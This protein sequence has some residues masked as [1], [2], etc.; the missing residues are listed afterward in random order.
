VARE[1]AAE[2]RG[3]SVREDLVPLAGRCSACGH[4][5]VDGICEVCNRSVGPM[6]EAEEPLEPPTSI[7]LPPRRPRITFPVNELS[8]IELPAPHP[9]VTAPATTPPVQP[10]ATER[11]SSF[12]K[13]GLVICAAFALALPVFVAQVW[14]LAS[15]DP[16]SEFSAIADINM[17]DTQIEDWSRRQFAASGGPETTDRILRARSAL[18]Q[19]VAAAIARDAE[20]PID[21]IQVASWAN[22]ARALGVHDTDMLELAADLNVQVAIYGPEISEVEGIE[23]LARARNLL[24][25]QRYVA[26]DSSE[27]TRL[28]RKLGDLDEMEFAVRENRGRRK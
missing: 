25:M 4:D 3:V 23:R 11:V 13:V 27:V 16:L 10:G 21:W 7:P 8:R 20:Q 22:I 14:R 6:A 1:D 17:S 5:V 2:D 18:E 19:R 28:E 26:R 24:Q 12:R 9:G 15:P